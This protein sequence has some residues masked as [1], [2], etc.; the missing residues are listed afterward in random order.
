MKKNEYIKNE[1]SRQELI[2]SIKRT[3]LQIMGIEEEEQANCIEDTFNKMK[4]S[5]ISRKRC[6]SRNK[7]SLEHQTDMT[8]TES[9]H[10]ILQLKHQVQRTR[11]ILNSARDKCQ[12]TCKAKAVTVTPD[13]S[14]VTFKARRE[15]IENNFKPRYSTQQSY[16]S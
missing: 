12:I 11:K 7:R 4:A 14:T 16:L 13:F 9:L 3:N 2:D 1:K 6:P 5:Q 15:W 8:K 10:S